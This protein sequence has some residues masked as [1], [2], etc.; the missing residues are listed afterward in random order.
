MASAA[1]R[2]FSI[3]ELLEQI[4]LE[5]VITRQ[6]LFVLQRVN[7]NFRLVIDGTAFQKRMYLRHDIVSRSLNPLLRAI[8][9]DTI[10][11][12]AGDATL[13]NFISVLEEVQERS[14]KR[15]VKLSE[16]GYLVPRPFREVEEDGN[17]EKKEAE[18]DLEESGADGASVNGM[19][20]LRI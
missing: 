8:K 15:H 4:L 16:V 3:D 14:L 19:A 12:E 18:P 10:K 20:N 11:L 17:V 2:A 13:G 6:D 1:N 5:K 9:L 7:R